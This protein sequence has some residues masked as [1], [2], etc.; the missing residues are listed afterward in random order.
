MTD[1]QSQTEIRSRPCPDCYLCSA[2]G[3]PLYSGL[4]DRLFGAPGEWSLR[5][6]PSSECGLV[7]LDPMPLEEDIGKAYETYYTHYAP[8]QSVQTGATLAKR[9]KQF[10]RTGYV[11]RYVRAGYIARKYGYCA[12]RVGIWQKWVGL[13]EYL[14]V[15]QRA[16]LDF[17]L[18]YLPANPSGRLLDVGCGSGQMLS[19]MAELGWQAEGVDFDPAAVQHAR[20]K[21]LQVRLGTLEE[22]R[23]PN[24]HFD[25]ITMSHLI[26][27]V[28][29]PIALLAEC[30]RILKPGGALVVVTP[31]VESYGHKRFGSH[32]RGLEPPRHL[33]L[34]SQRSLCTVVSEAGFTRASTATTIRDADRYLAASRALQRTGRH[35]MGAPEPRTIRVWAWYMQVLEWVVLKLKP[36]IG[37]ELALIGEKW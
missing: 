7:W 6:C 10:L 5:K 34:F 28:H 13:I 20:S 24:A 22:Q 18:M 11:G 30:Y 29:D 14:R 23:Y 3:D 32:W 9:L 27:H 12:E 1:Q 33:H 26:E 35:K 19:V 36:D 16:W 4:R 37:E 8:G 17:Q 21:G 15:G 25:A 2:R 31:N